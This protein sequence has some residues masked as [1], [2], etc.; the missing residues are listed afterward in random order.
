MK[1]RILSSL[2]FSILLMNCSNPVKLYPYNITISYGDINRIGSGYEIVEKTDTVM[3]ENDSAA[4]IK[5]LFTLAGRSEAQK[6][7]NKT[8][9]GKA[10]VYY[11]SVH[12][13]LGESVGN[14]LGISKI[15]S[16]NNTNTATESI[17]DKFKY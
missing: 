11:F 15:D 2:I 16:I 13:S 17:K 5:G 8:R 12:D 9:L 1:I 14:K 10:E 6:A 4:Y 3:V 7:L